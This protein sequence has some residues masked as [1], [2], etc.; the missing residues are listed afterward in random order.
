MG[1]KELLANKVPE[2]LSDSCKSIL[3]DLEEL[4]DTW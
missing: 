3:V 1:S 4:L 2:Y